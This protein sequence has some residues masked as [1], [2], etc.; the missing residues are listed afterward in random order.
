MGKRF[1]AFMLLQAIN[2]NV[3]VCTGTGWVPNSDT[4]RCGGCEAPWNPW[5]GHWDCDSTE[6][7]QSVCMLQCKVSY[8]LHK[9]NLTYIHEFRKDSG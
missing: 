2:G 4:M 8:L 6:N 7:G 3:T 5:N 1:L 9:F